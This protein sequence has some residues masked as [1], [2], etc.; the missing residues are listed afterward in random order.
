MQEIALQKGIKHLTPE[1]KEIIVQS[2]RENLAA[3]YTNDMIKEKGQEKNLRTP[4]KTKEK[5]L[6]L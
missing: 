5:D 2:L 4:N 6:E 1:T 3:S